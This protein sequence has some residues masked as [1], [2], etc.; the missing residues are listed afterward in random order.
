MMNLSPAVSIAG[1]R[2]K[3]GKVQVFDGLD[4][5]LAPGRIT[6]LMGPSGCGKSTLIRCVVG[7]QIVQ[8]GTVTV[9]GQPAGKPSLRRR[10][11]YSS[12]QASV[13]TDLSVGE[14][15]TY[16]ARL[17]GLPASESDRVI[18]A[19]GLAD[20][21]GQR[22]DDLSGGQLTRTSLAIAL[23]GSPELVVL[24]EPTVGLD[25]VLRAELWGI[26]RNLA[27]QGITLI[28]SSHVMDEANRCDDLLL[29]R[30]GRIVAHT[31]PSNLLAESGKSDADEAFLE[32]IRRHES[33]PRHGLDTPNDA[34]AA[35]PR[36]AQEDQR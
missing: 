18:T 4:L 36:H 7:I 19:V 29:M 26:F 9:L 27:D 3:R 2:V 13:Y 30:A 34:P 31:T 10:V 16:F 25:P 23:L 32:L 22:A 35:A 1:L 11:S 20:Q 12:Q 14:N 33:G 28:V 8:G 17:Y 21:R 6:G 5:D 24:D 15:V